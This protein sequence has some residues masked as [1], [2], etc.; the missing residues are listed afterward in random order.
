MLIFPIHPCKIL[1]QMQKDFLQHIFRQIAVLHDLIGCVV[2]K[3][4]TAL[5]NLHKLCFIGA[6]VHRSQI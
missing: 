6:V 1:G 2:H 5:I 4:F 3:P